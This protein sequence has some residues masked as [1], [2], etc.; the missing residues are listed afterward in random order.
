MPTIVRAGSSDVLDTRATVPAVW[1]GRARHLR[2]PPDSRTR[3]ESAV[4]KPWYC[5]IPGRLQNGEDGLL[6]TVNSEDPIT[7]SPPILFKSASLKI[8]LSR[9]NL[10]LL[11]DPQRPSEHF[12]GWLHCTGGVGW[13]LSQYD[14]GYAWLCLP[15]LP[16]TRRARAFY[17][18]DDELPLVLAVASGLQHGLITPPSTFASSLILDATS[19]YLILASLMGSGYTGAFNAT[20]GILSL[21]PVSRLKLFGGFDLG[22]GLIS[23]IYMLVHYAVRRLWQT[24]R[25]LL[26]LDAGCIVAGATGYIDGSGISTVPAITFLCLDLQSYPTKTT[27]V[28]TFKIGVYAPTIL[29]M[30]AVYS[31]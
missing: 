18:L 14:Y 28:N 19:A 30:L 3:R 8:A 31:K 27:S 20:T 22:N 1:P 17:A 6:V 5:R 16:F 4:T 12:G 29:P 2:S 13:E 15:T 23:A 25:I 21:M 10:P 9:R 26:G 11:S 24:S 7:P